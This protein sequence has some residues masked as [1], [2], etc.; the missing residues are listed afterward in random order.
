[1]KHGPRIVVIGAG[2][3]GLLM[4]MRLRAAGLERFTIYEKAS[5]VGGTWRDNTYPGLVCDV[6]AHLYRY[7]DRPYSE[8]CHRFARGPEIQRYLESVTARSDLARY[9]QFDTEVRAAAYRDG[10]WQIETSRGTRVV[11][12]VLIAATGFLHHPHVPSIPGLDG[13]AGSAFHTARWNHNATLAGARVGILGTGSTG[14]Q[15]VPAI[16]DTVGHLSVFQRTPQWLLPFPDH[17]Y[18]RFELALGRRIP[19]LDRLAY[20]AYG[21]AFEATFARAVIG[22]R[23]LQRGFQWLCQR[24]LDRHVKNPVLHAQLQPNYSA[25]CKRLLFSSA[26]YPAIQKPNASLVTAPIDRV[27]PEGIVTSDGRV[28]PLDVLILATG[29]RAHDY[30]RPIAITGTAGLS[31][32]TAWQDGPESYLTVA[33]PGFPN[34]FM[35]IGPGSPVG[36]FSLIAVAESQADYI[37]Q[38][39]RR[40][41]SGEIVA[42]EPTRDA[43]AR[44]NADRRAA[45][46]DTVWSTG[47]RS[48]Y[49]DQRG[50]PDVWPW[51]MGRFRRELR[52]PNFADY[53]VRR[54]AAR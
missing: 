32:Q 41:A 30:M 22:N 10:T 21:L 5:R 29:F 18:S 35:L 40:I 39:L 33:V 25:G 54:A 52:T 19:F 49:L 43:A 34:F 17:K 36:N 3:S 20:A 8:W 53:A 45:M 28:H 11:A 38:V 46:R 26:F 51:T 48:W 31:L 44:F 37:I 50:I 4:G 9:I 23:F 27:V 47:C 6:P 7:A 42:V 13:F 12:D 16:V 2:M 15:V 14:V 1:M 24:N